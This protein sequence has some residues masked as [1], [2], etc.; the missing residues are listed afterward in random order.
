MRTPL[1]IPPG[2][3][4]D[5]TTFA[6]PG[7]WADGNNVRFYFG[8][9]EVIGGWS[10][11]VTGLTGVCRNAIAWTDLA[12]AQ[13]LGF[14]TH[15][16]LQ[17][18]VG[19]EL[20]DIT[21]AGLAAGAIDG[22]GG[23][24]Y[25]TGP[26]GGGDY[27]E[28]VLV[29]FQA[30]TWSLQTYGEW[31]IANPRGGSIYRWQNNTANDA[32]I[33][34]DA[35]TAVNTILVTPERQLLALGCNEEVS[36]TYNPMCIRGS[37][38]EDI[39][40]WT[41]TPSN[42]AFEHILEGGGQI[43]GA[44]MLGGYVAVWT[45]SSVHLGQF[46]GQSGQTYRFDQVANNCGLIGPNAVTV[47]NQVAYWV[48]PDFQFYQWR[49]GSPPA[50][51]NC[52]IRKDFADNLVDSQVEKVC[53]AAVSKFGEIWWFYPDA[54]DGI[55]NSRY[56]AVSTL[57]GAWFKGEMVRTAAIDGNTTR[58]PLMVTP[59]GTAYFHEL[60]NS[61]DGGVL[62]WSITSSDQ[63][64][65]AAQQRVLVRGIW[66]DFEDQTGAIHLTV[67]MRDYPQSTPRLKGP[68]LLTEGLERRDFLVE[69]RVASFKL[70]GSSAPAFMRLGKPAFDVVASGQK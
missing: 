37:D 35:P 53:S 43:V 31:L 19:G 24:G 70:D 65:D 60:G 44:A 32:V 17:V 8:L 7:R 18:Y 58:F 21:P 45:D 39:T 25:G 4:T 22:S 11:A 68:Y 61:D 23:P 5:E 10:T 67:S 28:G 66:P 62:S 26:Y 13:N 59:G 1:A 12:N 47:F 38:I 48:T 16:A 54:R 51:M 57:D 52:P 30:R 15:S 27:G 34:T 3:V 49:P 63:Y 36:A 46:I 64:M 56:V 55:E 29:G 50:M 14:G 20:F 6:T 42:N 69:G 33:V 40:D 2:I 41:T 9:P